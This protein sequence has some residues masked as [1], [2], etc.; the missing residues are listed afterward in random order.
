MTDEVVESISDR[1]IEL[2]EQ[3]TGKKFVPATEQ[4]L[5][6]RIEKNILKTL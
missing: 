3:V 2:F 1:Y 5:L 6:A 4:D